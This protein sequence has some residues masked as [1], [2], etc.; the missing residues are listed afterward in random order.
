MVV[1]PGN[2]SANSGQVRIG[3]RLKASGPVHG[4]TGQT[5]MYS[6]YTH[7]FPLTLYTHLQPRS[8]PKG[9]WEV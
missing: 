5:V 2:M 3:C 8:L 4:K 7:L 6:I 9:S 1:K